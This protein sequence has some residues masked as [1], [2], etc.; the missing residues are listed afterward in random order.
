[1]TASLLTTIDGPAAV[2]RLAL[3]ELEVLCEELRGEILRVTAA[4][5]GHLA[6]NLGI[7]ELSVALHYVLDSP[8][9]RIIWDVGNQCYAHKIITGRRERF[10]TIRQANGLSGFVN[11]H[12]SPHD[13]MTAGHAGTALSAALSPGA[14]APGATAASAF[15]SLL[16]VSY[17]PPRIDWMPPLGVQPVRPCACRFPNLDTRPPT[18]LAPRATA[19]AAPGMLTAS[20]SSSA[21][22]P[23]IMKTTSF[24]EHQGHLTLQSLSVVTQE[25]IH[26]EHAPKLL[27]HNR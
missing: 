27:V 10:S 23:G 22:N 20:F 3:D 16:P 4:N 8:R 19:P 25:G 14:L 9:D 21:W 24:I 1:M 18:P 15:S 7:V 2:K 11:R 13:H 17:A 5:G 12:E 6:T 26:L